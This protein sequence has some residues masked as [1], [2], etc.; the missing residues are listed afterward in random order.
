MNE[1]SIQ[2]ELD[3]EIEEPTK[4]CRDCYRRKPLSGFNRDRRKIDGRQAYCRP[5][6]NERSRQYGEWFRREHGTDPKSA[7]RAARKAA[8][9]AVVMRVDHLQFD[10][11]EEAS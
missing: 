5:C 11:L 10:L 2:L 9:E 4:Q 8:E 7:W 1:E 6:D 3:I